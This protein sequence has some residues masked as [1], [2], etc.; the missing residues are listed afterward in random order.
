MTT[1]SIPL[2]PELAAYVEEAVKE[3]GLSR[4]ALVRKA[5]EQYRDEQAVQAVLSAMKEPS[6]SGDLD[7]L[8]A[9]LN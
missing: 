1:L 9:Q 2:T 3:T 6:L 8:A 4:A 5:L 7:E